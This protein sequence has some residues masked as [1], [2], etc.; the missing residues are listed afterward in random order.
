MPSTDPTPRRYDHLL[1]DGLAVQIVLWLVYGIDMQVGNAGGG[2]GDA[3][4]EVGW[5]QARWKSV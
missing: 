4:L 2:L 1:V 3:E 5:D